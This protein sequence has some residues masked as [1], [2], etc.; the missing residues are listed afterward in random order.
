MRSPGQLNCARPPKWKLWTIKNQG[1]LLSR[2]RLR[3]QR[4]KVKLEVITKPRSTRSHKALKVEVSRIEESMG[5]RRRR[6]VDSKNQSRERLFWSR[7]HAK[8]FSCYTSQ[9]FSRAA[10][11]DTNDFDG[12]FPG[13]TPACTTTITGLA[14]VFCH[15]WKKRKCLLEPWVKPTSAM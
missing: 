4:R 15:R 7:S 13:D 1:I 5:F 6:R 14:G 9:T 11:D 8:I 3:W 12:F 10:E 2:A